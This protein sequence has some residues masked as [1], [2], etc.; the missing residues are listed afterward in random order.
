MN[1]SLVIVSKDEPTLADTLDAIGP[2]DGINF[3]EVLVVDA[4][5]GRL[6]WAH[7]SHPWARW[8]DFKPQRPDRCTIAQQRNIGVRA[9]AGDIIVFTDCGCVPQEW[10]SQ[11]LL[12]PILA[13]DEMMTAG[14]ARAQQPSIYSGP[15][16][17]GNTSSPYVSGAATINMAF[18]RELFDVVEG[19]D[20][21]FE[22]GEDL[23]FTWRLTGSGYRIR[24]VPDAVVCHEWGGVARQ[25]RRSL[26]YGRGWGHLMR[27]HPGK[28]PSALAENPVPLLYP[29]FVVGLP[30]TRKWPGYPALLLVPLWRARKEERPW[31]VVAD[32]LALG[33]GVL[34]DVVAPR[35]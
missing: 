12:A 33:V 15:R 9:A 30:L 25:L 13:G 22:A 29:L 10:W 32:H 7:R 34:L 26:A 17:S 14:P 18:R 2:P 19:F 11:R 4:S 16:W 1:V 21:T 28:L 31:L 3:S 27:K 6:E 23:D 24:W 8:I 35:R 5:A 20:E